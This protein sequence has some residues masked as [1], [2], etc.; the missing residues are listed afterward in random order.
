MAHNLDL[1]NQEVLAEMKRLWESMTARQREAVDHAVGRQ[2]DRFSRA[3][4]ESVRGALRDNPRTRAA[5]R[6]EILAE[7]YAGSS[8]I[9][10]YET[11][12]AHSQ[13]VPKVES[14][15]RG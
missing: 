8:Q 4:P 10:T 3:V 6:N 1:K 5:Y 9:G 11:A 14:A 2:L 13:S 15:A 7:I 12:Y